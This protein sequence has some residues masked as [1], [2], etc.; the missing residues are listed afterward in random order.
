MGSSKY[1]LKKKKITGKDG[2]VL[3]VKKAGMSEMRLS[4]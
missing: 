1:I 4:E 2:L 3:S